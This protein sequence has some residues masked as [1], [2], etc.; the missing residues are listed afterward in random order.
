MGEKG[1]GGVKN[2]KKM[3]DIIYGR[4]LFSIGS[5]CKH[6]LYFGFSGIYQILKY[7]T[8]SWLLSIV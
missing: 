2:L 3:G 7:I 6:N 4:P 8:N 5:L 1:E